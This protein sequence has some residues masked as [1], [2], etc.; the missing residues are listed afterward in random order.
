MDGRVLRTRRLCLGAP[1]VLVNARRRPPRSEK[2]E[3][4]TPLHVGGEMKTDER[5][6]LSRANTAK[7][8]GVLHRTCTRYFTQNKSI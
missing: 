1:T 6:V 4:S 3:H 7:L 2:V 5:D 8:Y